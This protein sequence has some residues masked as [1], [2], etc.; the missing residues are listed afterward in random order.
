M[1]TCS[2]PPAKVGGQEGIDLEHPVFHIVKEPGG[3]KYLTEYDVPTEEYNEARLQ[4]LVRRYPK[5]SPGVAEHIAALEPFLDISI[6]AGF[7]YGVN[8]AFIFSIKT[9][10]LGHKVNQEG[11]HY[12]I[13]VFFFKTQAHQK[14]SPR[15]LGIN[16]KKKVD[17]NTTSPVNQHA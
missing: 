2:A 8:K 16:F 15:G 13:K 6:M 10:L 1:L 4:D 11:A 9:T 7:S 17:M 12:A 5:L 3:I 14:L